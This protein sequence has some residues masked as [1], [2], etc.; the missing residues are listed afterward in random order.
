MREWYLLAH[1]SKAT[2]SLMSEMARLDV[3]VFCPVRIS[4]RKR[5]DRPS[6]QRRELVLFPGYLFLKFDPEVVHTSEITAFSGAHRFIG[7]AN[8]IATVP[9]SVIA[10]LRVALRLQT[11]RNA[12]VVE[13]QNLNSE[14]AKAL[15]LIIEMQSET[16]RKAAFH[17]LLEQQRIFGAYSS[18]RDS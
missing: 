18:L 11:N 2:Q 1:N 16:Q 5:P 9:E 6:P 12:S 4:L 13:Y 10:D 7:F 14:T 17:S 15:H 8:K 3:E